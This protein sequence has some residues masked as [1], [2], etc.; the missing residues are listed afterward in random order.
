VPLTTI[1]YYLREG[2]LPPGEARAR[3]QADYGADHLRRL[4]LIR[5]LR[6]V[7]GLTLAKVKAVLDAL[8]APPADRHLLLGLVHQALA[9]PPAPTASAEELA[10]ARSEVDRLIARL[11]W[12]VSPE[13]PART[14]LAAALAALRALGLAE[15]AEVFAPYARTAEQIAAFELGAVAASAESA[16]AVE[17]T[18][19]GTVVFEAA[20][21]ALRRLAQE[22]HSALL[23]R[24]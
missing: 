21:S 11:G 4:R 3:N 24:T 12:Q 14:T 7:G 5:V 22:H 15:G 2:L 9:P 18:V 20:L 6:E 13:A 23:F 8:D 16:D 19:V 17:L 10:A 1:K